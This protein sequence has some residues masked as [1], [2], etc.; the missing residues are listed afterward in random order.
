[1]ERKELLFFMIKLILLFFL[2]FASPIE[3]YK[4]NFSSSQKEVYEEYYLLTSKET[5]N[6]SFHLYVGKSKNGISYAAM[7]INNKPKEYKLMYASGNSSGNSL[8]EFKINGRGDTQFVAFT[9]NK[10][11]KIFVATRNGNSTV[12]EAN[13]LGG[14]N[15]S[16]YNDLVKGK[17]K[18]TGTN[19]GATI[20]T[21]KE[22]FGKN[23][24]LSF[25]KTINI[26]LGV[27]IALATGFL[28]TFLV[29]V[30]KRKGKKGTIK[31]EEDIIIENLEKMIDESMKVVK[32]EEPVFF[33]PKK[34]LTENG[35][36]TNYKGMSE[37]QKE[38]IM[39]FLIK[40]YD[41]KKINEKD[42]KK[43]IIE[44]WKS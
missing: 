18:N 8:F 2:L 20:L 41:N 29:I 43:E 7:L 15:D 36:T 38:E 10:S 26:I 27:F 1:M 3:E 12:F 28:I 17:T 25:S 34:L 16:I 42:Y 5:D 4:T 40:A 32:T 30:N 6:F 37:T 23:E 9:V 14:L 35:F 13:I 24:I 11:G 33:E 44:L 39:L 31:Q 19:G 22:I 21:D